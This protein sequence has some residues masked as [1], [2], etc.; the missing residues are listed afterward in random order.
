MIHLQHSSASCTAVC[1]KSSYLSVAIR[2][3]LFGMVSLPIMMSAHA[4]DDSTKTQTDAWQVNATKQVADNTADSVGLAASNQPNAFDGVD[5][6]T[7]NQQAQT[8]SS[9]ESSSVAQNTDTATTWQSDE[10][11]ATT[12]SD[13]DTSQ[14]A[15]SRSLAKLA[16]NY[17]TK[18]NEQARCQGVWLQ[19]TTQATQRF[20]GDGNPL[21]ADGIF[22]QADYGYYDAARYAELSGNVIVEQNGQRVSAD[23]VELDTITG[24]AVASGQV[25]FSDAGATPS[26]TGLIGVAENLEYST[27]GKTGT[28]KDVAFASTAINAHGYAGQMDKLSDNKYRLQEVMFST[29]PPTERKWYLDAD[30]ID[31]DNNTGRAIAK[32]T[33]LRIKDVPVLYLPYF[34]FPIDSRRASGF[35]LPNIGFGATNSFEI[36]TP[37]YFNLAPNYDATLTPTIFSNRN[38]MLTGEFRY[39]TENF[40][41][42]TLNA[43]YLPSD[44]RYN[45][46][47]RSRVRFDHAWQPKNFNKINT[48]AQYQ[49]VSDAKYLSDFNT[50]GIDTIALNLPRRIGA[51]FAGE[52]V[53]ADLRAEDFQRLDGVNIDGT[54]ILDKD[55]PYA[56]LPQLSVAYQLPKTSLGLPDGIKIDGIHNSAYFKKTIKDNSEAEKSGV[57]MF[58]QISASYP[59][60]RSWGYVTP[61]LSLSHLYASYDEDSLADQKLTKEEGSYSIFAPTLSI[62]SGLFFEKQGSPFGWYDDSLGGYQLLTPRLHYTYTPFKDQQKLPNFETS[63]AKLSYEQLLNNSW[64]LGYDRI[65]DLHAI[66][67]AVNYRYIDSTGVT[68]FEG[69][70]AE[71]LLLSDT[72]VGIDKSE[73]FSGRASGMAWQASLQ[74]KN[75]LWIEAAGSFDTRYRPSSVIAQVRYQPSDSKL[76]NIGVIER[77]EHKATNQYALSAYTAS[78]IFPVNNRWRLMGQVQYDYQQ[79]YLMDSLFGVNYEDCCYGL[80]VYARRY[81]DAINPS[82]SPNTAIMAEIRLSG[83]TSV[84]RLNRLLSEKILGYDQVQNAWQ[85]AY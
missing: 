59:I 76:F 54:P 77:K 52:Y 49:Y 35:L 75:N 70:I 78:A 25:L 28:A 66:T 14:D 43:S 37:Y 50:L 9:S 17:H 40:G 11:A 7:I 79:G 15:R 29:C 62:D 55:R 69:G 26:K 4:N 48:Y 72:R 47:D 20:D 56:R 6:A 83:I 58:N 53:S 38:P 22:A 24:R 1:H 13:K 42:G 31:I 18:P 82:L 46:Q 8:L 33:T 68:R 2:C 64:F 67:P 21:A 51:S 81:R 16:E 57:R 84:G 45:N 34:N 60:L 23:K 39:L 36:S 12:K 74:P 10:N 61:K 71:Q 80:S 44:K 65:Q 85:Q 5:F 30:S 73:N 41:A 3:A 63:I 32:N 27:D 19:P